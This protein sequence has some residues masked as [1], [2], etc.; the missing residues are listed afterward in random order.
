MSASLI[1]TNDFVRQWADVGTAVLEAVNRVGESGWYI[2]GPEVANFERA[3]AVHTRREFAIGCGSGLDAIEI[4]LR[5]LDLQPGQKVLT[6]ALSAFATTLAIIRASGRPVFVDVDATG[7]IDLER[8]VHLLERDPSIRFF[9]PVHLFGHPCNLDQLREVKSRF[10]LRVVE[11]CAQ[12][13]GAQFGNQAVGSVGDLSALSFYPTK[14]LGAVGDGGAILTDHPSYAERARALRDYGQTSKYVHDLVG[15][16]S[17]LDELHAAILGRALLPKLANWA[18]RR[19]K[20]AQQYIQ[21]IRNPSVQI[22]LPAP[23]SRP[24][25]HL[26]ATLIDP[27]RRDNFCAYLKAS[28]V[29]TGIHYPQIIPRQKALSNS[30]LCE[31]HG[32]LTRAEAFA[33]GEVSLPIHPYLR[34][35]EVA[36]IVKT[37]NAWQG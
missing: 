37:V 2:L 13:I 25:W 12:A 35:D 19:E 31:V 36:T 3:I 10:Q 23:H 21:E 9:V 28:G 32:E 15:L 1:A 16:N 7:S 33:A 26:F 6:T 27:N 20:I 11:D 24:A 22:V 8:C 29:G 18:Q 14:N 17:R 5:C 4:S 30:S 34:D